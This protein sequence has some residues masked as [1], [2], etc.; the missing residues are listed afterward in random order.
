M[1][2]LDA[3]VIQDSTRIGGL[4]GNRAR[5]RMSAAPGEA[6][7][8]VGNEPVIVG[9]GRLRQERGKG[10]GQHGAVDEQHRLPRPSHVVLQLPASDWNAIG[11]DTL[12]GWRRGT[13]PPRQAVMGSQVGCAGSGIAAQ[14][15]MEPLGAGRI[16]V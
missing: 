16:A 13:E 12:L 9:K 1:G 3:K 15:I 14:A 4:L 2:A 11:H 6:A 8:V 7:P 5:A 10:I